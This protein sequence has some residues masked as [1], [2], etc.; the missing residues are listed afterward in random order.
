MPRGPRL[1]A[2]GVV[3]HVVVRG[4]EQRKIFQNDDDR[5]DFIRR[6]AR[7][8]P[9]TQTTCLAW[10]VLPNHVHLA[11]R[12]GP[13]G[14]SF[15]MRRLL[16]G[17]AVAFNRRHGR[18]GHLFQNRYQ[19]IVCEEE[20]Y[21][22]ALVRYVH[23]NPLRAGIV[24]GLKA[25]AEHPWCGHGALLGRVEHSW[26]E[27]AEVLARFGDTP[28]QARRE[29]AAFVA[30]EADVEEAPRTDTAELLAAGATAAQLPS[31][32]VGADPNGAWGSPE[33]VAGLRARS[34]RPPEQ[35]DASCRF[36][37]EAVCRALGLSPQALASGRRTRPLSNGRAL[38]A[39]VA[40]T[41]YRITGTELAEALGMSPPA[42]T[43]AERRG[44]RLLKRR[45][46]LRS[47]LREFLN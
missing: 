16:T 34:A 45:V 40:R 17:Y 2:P 37:V 35:P 36:V 4:I 7:L 33:F 44:A 22:L 26:Q 12:S 20:P 38:V 8:L 41:R 31:R 32:P 46:D 5:A 42:V 13:R 19:S 24:N 14:L 15:L 23:L 18:V 10:C 27:T 30:A 6:I 39:Y 28:E 1:D 21:L 47:G 43:F 9:D 3:H 29:Y 25:L 11:L